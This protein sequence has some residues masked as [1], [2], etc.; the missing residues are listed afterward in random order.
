MSSTGALDIFEDS[1]SNLW[2]STLRG[3]NLLDRKT[4]RF[5]HYFLY[6][7]DISPFGSNLMTSILEDK[8]GELWI[9]G[10]NGSGINLLNRETGR[11]INYLKGSGIMCVYEDS[12]GVLWAG[13]NDGLYT[14][15]READNFTRFGDFDSMTGIPN[16]Y[17]LTED[18]QKYIWVGTTDGIVRI[19]PARDETSF[20]GEN[21][22]VEKNSLTWG[23]VFKAKNGDIYFGNT[24]G[25][26]VINPSELLKNSKA[27]VIVFTDFKI[28]DVSIK[29]EKYGPLKQ[30]LT[31][32][33]EIRLKYSENVFSFDFTVIDYANPEQNQLIYYLENYDKTWLKPSSERRAYYF[34][35]PQGK[36]TFHVKA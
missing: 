19:N 7:D 32:T 20:Y 36:Y 11:F 8:N 30:S 33:K 21:F 3:L 2:I 29:P 26:Y 17:N 31:D 27:P 4:N 10:W 1:K 6:P 18:N 12:D 5:T 34:N 9:G 35:I 23:S 28:T 22:G 25:Y 24:T 15:N 16:A 13:G 14:Y